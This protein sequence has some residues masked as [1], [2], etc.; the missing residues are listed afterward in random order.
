MIDMHL[1]AFV[2]ALM[3]FVVARRIFSVADIQVDV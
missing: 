1:W 2:M 3:A